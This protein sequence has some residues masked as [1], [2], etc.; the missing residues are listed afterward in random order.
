MDSNTDWV[1]A[2]INSSSGTALD[3]DGSNDYVTATATQSLTTYPF[4]LS[5][6]G[7]FRAVPSIYMHWLAVGTSNSAY[8]AIGGVGVS[9]TLRLSITGRNSTFTQNWTT[10]SYSLDTWINLVGVFESATS[11]KLYVNGAL[12]LTGTTNVNQLSNGTGIR[13]GSQ[14][15]TNYLNGQIA[16]GVIWNRALSDSEV[17]ES[18]QPAPPQQLRHIRQQAH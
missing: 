13:L 3:F 15:F 6:W 5:S 4:T 17:T 12:V 10:T 11:R 18:Y 14:F 16:E 9:G 8:F 2:T 1:S 7:L